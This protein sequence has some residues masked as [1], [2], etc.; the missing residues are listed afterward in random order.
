MGVP[1][2]EDDMEQAVATVKNGKKKG[3]KKVKIGTAAATFNIP[4]NTLKYRL[5]GNF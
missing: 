4:Y 5:T 1:W 3:N 2:S